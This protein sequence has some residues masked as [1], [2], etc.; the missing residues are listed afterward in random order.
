M[1]VQSLA[2]LGVCVI[3]MSS[4]NWGSAT[5]LTFHWESMLKLL[6][7]YF[8]SASGD[9][10]DL[11]LPADKFGKSVCTSRSELTLVS[12]CKGDHWPLRNT[13]VLDS[14]DK[15]VKKKKLLAKKQW[16]TTLVIKLDRGFHDVMRNWGTNT[17]ETFYLFYMKVKDIKKWKQNASAVP[18][19]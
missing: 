16:Q 9:F 1:V 11:S 14:L 4:G 12:V 15:E 18:H 2:T 8:A 13:K 19:K 5:H 17:K 3:Y 7:R 10:L 6:G